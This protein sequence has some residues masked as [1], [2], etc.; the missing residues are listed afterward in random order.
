M[1]WLDRVI[2]AVAV[3]AVVFGISYLLRRGKGPI[4]SQ[5]ET[6]R[7]LMTE[8][9]L[10]SALVQVFR[11]DLKVRK[12]E[13][14]SWKLYNKRIQFLGK[15]LPAT[16][17]EAFNEAERI[18]QLITTAR[19]EHSDEGLKEIDTAKLE[20]LL[21]KSKEGLEEWL[22]IHTGRKDIPP[23]YPSLMDTLF[24]GR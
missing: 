22:L 6:V 17:E 10:N 5:T 20:E 3:G 2:F 11:S 14:N 24:G 8:A 4:Q 9:R 18:N 19:K 12:F 15:T 13:T 21:T 23:K 16:M 1:E 7:D